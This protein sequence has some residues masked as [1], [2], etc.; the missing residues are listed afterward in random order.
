MKRFA[1]VAAMFVCI[2]VPFYRACALP[3][4][5]DDVRLAFTGD[6]LRADG[7]RLH[8]A[9]SIFRYAPHEA[10][11]S[12]AQRLRATVFVATCTLTDATAQR[13][14]TAQRYGRAA[15]DDITST[16]S[17]ADVQIGS[18][19][20]HARTANGSASVRVAVDDAHVHLHLVA[21]GMQSAGDPFVPPMA[22]TGEID[23]SAVRGDSTFA[24]DTAPA[25]VDGTVADR[26]EAT[27][28]ITGAL[29]TH[30][31]RIT[32]FNDDDAQTHV[33][34]IDPDGRVTRFGRADIQIVSSAASRWMSPHTPDVYPAL[35]QV[36][37]VP[38]NILVSLS[39]A[40]ADQEFVAT[41]RADAFWE[42]AVLVET[43]DPDPYRQEHGDGMLTVTG[44]L[45]PR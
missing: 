30:T 16:R 7:H 36:R 22:T 23:G 12:P 27:I 4:A 35:W 26:M 34:M 1:C 14:A 21:R 17:A 28:H 37:I 13:H 15:F 43:L 41:P 18:W 5:P 31:L 42:G 3:P 40:M 38:L 29:G 11:L 19:S 9:I 24:V 25:I 8:Y 39:P 6:V 10:G 44:R 45:P 32:R 20:L 33:T 2:G